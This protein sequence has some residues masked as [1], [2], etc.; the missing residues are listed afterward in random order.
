M[1][2][3]KHKWHIKSGFGR[4]SV[5]FPRPGAD[6]WG[7]AC[8]QIKRKKI[9][10]GGHFRPGHFFENMLSVRVTVCFLIGLSYQSLKAALMNPVKSLRLE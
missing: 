5:Y 8:L 2:G 1:G 4:L 9:L 10:A 3:A 6:L 7:L